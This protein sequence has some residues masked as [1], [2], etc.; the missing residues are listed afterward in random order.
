MNYIKNHKVALL[1]ALL[2]A[3]I[4]ILSIVKFAA[5]FYSGYLAATFYVMTL[6]STEPIR[7]I[8]IVICT[9]VVITIRELNKKHKSLTFVALALLLVIGLIPY[10][11][12]VTLGALL[13]INNANPEQFRDDARILFDEYGSNTKFSDSPQRV[14]NRYALFPRSKLPPSILRANIGDVFILEKYI[15]IEKFGLGGSFRGFIV[16]R[17]GADIWKSDK[18]ITLLED[19]SYCWKIRIIDGLYWYHA[20]PVEEEDARLDFLSE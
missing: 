3:G 9:I 12:F 8:L 1:I 5:E 7:Y 17:E 15:L 11:H 13:S 10:G 18:P 2:I 4:T 6:F 16:F 19:C 20:A 14:I